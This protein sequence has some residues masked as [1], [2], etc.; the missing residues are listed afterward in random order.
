MFMNIKGQTTGNKARLSS[1]TFSQSTGTRRCATFWY[2][3]QGT[4]VGSLTV[5]Q[6]DSVDGDT[7]RWLV[8][9]SQ[10]SQWNFGQVAVSQDNDYRVILP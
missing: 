2:Y 5:K 6:V 8:G 9:S 1:S 10:G 3:L 7:D 4:G